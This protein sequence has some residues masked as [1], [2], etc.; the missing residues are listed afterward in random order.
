MWSTYNRAIVTGAFRWV[1]L[2]SCT[3]L[4]GW[5]VQHFNLNKMCLTVVSQYQ[6]FIRVWVFGFAM[7]IKM[8]LHPHK[9]SQ[10]LI[11]SHTNLLK[12]PRQLET[13]S[14]WGFCDSRCHFVKIWALYCWFCAFCQ[15]SSRSLP[16]LISQRY[17]GD[18]FILPIIND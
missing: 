12:I 5:R 2:S 13:E 17:R 1:E 7:L 4:C 6:P 14:Y 3:Y 10:A 11:R 15:K 16:K 8:L 18:R 9:L